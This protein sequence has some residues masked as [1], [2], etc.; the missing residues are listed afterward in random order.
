MNEETTTDLLKL[1]LADFDVIL[2]EEVPE[3]AQMVRID[4]KFAFHVSRIPDVLNGIQSQYSIV[5]AAGKR[6][7]L[8]N[9]VYLDT[10]EFLFFNR[11]HRG[12]LHRDK[13]RF[14][15]YS[16]TGT[17]FLEVKHKSNTGKTLKERILRE[18]QSLD[19]D[20]RA[21]RF[22]SEEI[23]EIDPGNLKLSAQVN[24][25]RIQFISKDRHE[26]FSIDF[27]IHAHLDENSVEF[28][29]V[30]ILEI[31]QDYRLPTPIVLRMRDM[32][33]YE[34]GLSK[35]CLA[36]TMLKPDLKSNRFKADLRRLRKITN[37]QLEAV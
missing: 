24:Y 13:V 36:M 6:I 3:G 1:A 7:S 18:T 32:R 14:R 28:G 34:V 31:K 2:L 8:Y 26:R 33:Y 12:Y 27:D 20:S 4:R 30:A 5:K 17:T 23:S 22:L 29:P 10:P 35:Y 9:S 25:Q 19:L 37:E 15:S 11:H 21:R 16:N